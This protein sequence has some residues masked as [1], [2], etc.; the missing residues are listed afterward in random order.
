MKKNESTVSLRPLRS[1]PHKPH[2]QGQGVCPPFFSAV[3]PQPLLRMPSLG[4]GTWKGERAVRGKSKA[5]SLGRVAA[6]PAPHPGATSFNVLR[7]S[8]PPSI[9]PTPPPPLVQWPW[10]NEE[11]MQREAR[12]ETVPVGPTRPILV[13]ICAH[14]SH[15]DQIRTPCRS[16][17][18]A[19]PPTTVTT[20]WA[21]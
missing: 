18:R 17:P 13:P 21:P 19:K 4:G 7:C 5:A 8:S 6:L 9:P 14:L 10:L 12:T 2:I 15:S 1:M 3:I 11:K 16:G 20:T